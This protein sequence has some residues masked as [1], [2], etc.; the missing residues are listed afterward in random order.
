[1]TP[2]VVFITG[3]SSGIGYATA[4]A[5]ARQGW[6]VIATAR[7]P[8][9][10]LQLEQA[11][12][13]LSTPHGAL[14][15]VA[16]DVQNWDDVNDAVR[17]GVV[18]FG[19]L[20][21]LV[22]N[23]GIGQR[24]SV[25]DSQ[26]SDIETLLRTNIDGVLHSVRAA[27]PEMRKVGKGHVVIISS[28]VYNMTT[29]YTAAYAASKAFVSSIAS[30]LRFELEADHIGVTDLLVGRTESEFNERRLGQAGYGAQASGRLPRMRAEQV[31]AAVVRAC[32]GKG[33]RYALRLF[34]RL[35]VLGNMLV[36]SL[37]GRM[38]MRQYK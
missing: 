35:I 14:L 12:D 19:R 32:D 36:P 29:P 7:R 30:A 2:R 10:L 27:V 34:D 38:A 18:R 13:A 23:A 1:M 26:W 24:G 17:E 8:D 22:A 21:A 16:A 9:R 25:V 4:L 28:V 20:D 5:F 15:P 31:A 33:G 11:V 37:I 3:A 6:N